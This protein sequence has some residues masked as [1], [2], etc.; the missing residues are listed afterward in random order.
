MCEKVKD[1]VSPDVFLGIETYPPTFSVER[2]WFYMAAVEVTSFD[3]L[4]VGAVAKVIPANVYAVFTYKGKLPGRIG[5]VFGYIYG[6]WLP[7]SGCKQAGPYDFERYG[8]R[9]KGPDN[10]DSVTEICVPIEK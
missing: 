7:K 9:F 3:D 8:E 4:P 2:K 1:R 6:E 5:E 10:E